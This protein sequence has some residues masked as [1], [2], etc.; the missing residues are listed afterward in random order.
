MLADNF[1][2]RFFLQDF[3]SSRNKSLRRLQIVAGILIGC[4]NPHRNAPGLLVH[5]ISTVVSP[6]FFDIMT[7]PWQC[8]FCGVESWA[9]LDQ[10]PFC[11]SQQ[12][13]LHF[14]RLTF[15]E[16]FEGED[17]RFLVCTH[18]WEPMREREAVGEGKGWKGFANLLLE[19]MANYVPRRSRF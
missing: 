3:D 16:A 10:P 8:D 19:P 15:H 4:D 14:R 5:T 18:V 6:T 13:P 12:A 9:D 11:E 7:V 1:A 17:T 2:A